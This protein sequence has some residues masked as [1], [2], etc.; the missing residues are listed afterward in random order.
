[1]LTTDWLVIILSPISIICLILFIIRIV[2]IKF[3]RVRR[4]FQ[5]LI[6]LIISVMCYNLAFLTHYFKFEN[7][8]CLQVNLFVIADTSLFIWVF[9][10]IFF[11]YHAI[12][13]RDNTKPICDKIEGKNWIIFLLFGIFFPMVYGPVAYSL[14]IW[15]DNES[16]EW[17]CMNKEKYFGKVYSSILY[18]YQVVVFI[19]VIMIFLFTFKYL[20]INNFN[21]KISINRYKIVR[22]IVILHTIGFLSSLFQKYFKNFV[23]GECALIF[24]YFDLILTNSY[25]II[26]AIICLKFTFINNDMNQSTNKINSFLTLTEEYEI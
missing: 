9:A 21:E 19:F 5:V 2:T 7:N 6:P 17:C 12:S 13:F 8:C 23:G 25:G 11:T 1:M 15:V 18:F 24:T 26:Y 3:L 22:I 16:G 4:E 20:K 10:T 14:K